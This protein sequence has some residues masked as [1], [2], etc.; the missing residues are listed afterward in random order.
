[1]YKLDA[2][3]CGN[4]TNLQNHL[5]RHHPETLSAKTCKR[6]KTVLEKAFAVKLPSNSPCA[7]K[8]TEAVVTFICKDIRPYSIV[9]DG[10]CNRQCRENGPCCGIDRAVEHWLFYAQA[11]LSLS[12]S[13]QNSSC[14]RLL[15]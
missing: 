11:L 13:S 3:Y 1:M 6:N 2:K 7:Q 4:T 10:H 9:N 15:G 14:C 5:N 12:S 8:L